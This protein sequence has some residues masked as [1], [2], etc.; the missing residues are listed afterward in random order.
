MRIGVSS[1]RYG[2][3]SPGLGGSPQV[4][5]GSLNGCDLRH[6]RCRRAGGNVWIRNRQLQA[7][8]RRRRGIRRTGR[9]DGRELGQPCSQEFAQTFPTRN[10]GQLAVIRTV[11]DSGSIPGEIHR[12][13]APNCIPD[14]N[15]MRYVRWCRPEALWHRPGRPKAPSRA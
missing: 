12:Q 9:H 14:A 11:E 13:F 2:S 7:T 15:P 3:G 4:H 6:G 1:E 5:S 8:S 10:T